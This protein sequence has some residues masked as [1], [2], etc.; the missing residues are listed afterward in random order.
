MVVGLEESEDKTPLELVKEHFSKAIKIKNIS[1][2]AAYRVGS[3]PGS[4]SSYS[5]PIVVRFNN[6]AHRNRVWRKRAAVPQEDGAGKIRIQADLP[7][8]L[9]EGMQSMYRVLRAATKLKEFDSAKIN[10]YQLE[11]NGKVYQVTDLENLPKKIR[12]STLLTP[13]SDSTLVFFSRHSF[14]SNHHPS[15]FKIGQNTFYSMEQFLA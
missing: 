2:A 3:Q 11:L 1:I 5:R 6:L 10:D 15:T 8:L 13:R 7:K 9:R 4:G 14:L 12:P